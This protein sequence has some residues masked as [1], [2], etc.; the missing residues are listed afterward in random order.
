MD[1]TDHP[2]VSSRGG[3]PTDSGCREPP[4]EKTSRVIRP[5]RPDKE[6][7]E[8]V[9]PWRPGRD[10]V[11]F[12]EEIGNRFKG[13]LE[14]QPREMGVPEVVDWEK[15]SRFGVALPDLPH[16]SCAIDMQDICC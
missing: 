1:I 15:L 7:D 2:Y 9:T 5:L 11:A 3:K 12:A 16:S 6:Q 8:L 4:F 14:L 10:A 13:A